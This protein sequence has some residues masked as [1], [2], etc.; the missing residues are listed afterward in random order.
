MRHLFARLSSCLTL[1]LTLLVPLPAAADDFEFARVNGRYTRPTS[2]MVPVSQGPMTVRLSSPRNSL[3]LLGHQLTLAP[4][5]DG[6]HDARLWTRFEGD[7]D[8]IAELEIGGMVQK[9]ND[10]VVLPAQNLELNGR[11][12][13][14][15]GDEGYLIEL[16]EMQQEEVE[17]RIRSDLA[18]GIVATC[19]QF[20]L[21]TLGT[22]ACDGIEGGLST[23]TVPLPREGDTFLL[24]DGLLTAEDRIRLDAYL[25]RTS[26]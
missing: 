26:R 23:T 18:K 11:I 12:R 15:R 24:P 2:D 3:H 20:S 25:R 14:R 5:S 8:L 21:L 6:S 17:V 7:G 9:L 4:R 13:M 16:V 22:G 19:R 10:R 1:C